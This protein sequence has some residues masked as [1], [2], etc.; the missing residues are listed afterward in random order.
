VLLLPELLAIKQQAFQEQDRAISLV[1]MCWIAA[2]FLYGGKLHLLQ[3]ECLQVQDL[4][5]QSGEHVAIAAY[6]AFDLASLYYAWNELGQAEA[7]L[8]EAIQQA[9]RWQDMNLLVWSYAICVKVL[10]AAEKVVE[11]EEALQQAQNLMQ[12]SGFTVYEPDVMAAQVSLWL[13]QGNL[14]AAGIWARQYRFHPEALEYMRQEEYLALA[15]VYLEQH[16]YEQCLQLLVP[17]LRRMEQLE[18]VWDVI[19]LL[20]LQ[21]V[22]LHGLGEMAQ[23]RQCTVRLLTLTE[24]EGY[25]RVY[26]DGGESMRCV[27][28]SLRDTPYTDELPL[29]TA[30]IAYI[31]TLLAAF[32]QAERRRFLRESGAD[33]P[34]SQSLPAEP[35]EIYEPLSP[36]EQRVLSLLVAGRTY[37]EIAQEL[38]VSTNTIKTQVSS[39]YRKL[40][41]SRRAEAST[42]AR[43]LHLL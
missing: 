10:L 21:I 38:I 23:A 7:S 27:L 1:A 18:R 20:A 39:I 24:P 32:A 43:Q 22:A 30:H 9:E 29:P 17:L 40:G 34:A 14:S 4:L 19:H 37:A 41:V 2:A 3:Q 16:C 26:L 8:Q 6:P 31:S 5:R 42:V 28:Q 15:R 36:Q 13:A 33:G 35:G 25:I 12:R 11:A